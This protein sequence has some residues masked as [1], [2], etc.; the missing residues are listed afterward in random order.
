MPNLVRR[1]DAALSSDEVFEIVSLLNRV[2]PKPDATVAELV[3]AFP[4]AQRYRRVAEPEARE[5]AMRHLIREEAGLIA[6]ALTF[7]R[8]ILSEEGEVRLMALSGVCVMPSHRG[9]GLGRDIARDSLARVDRGDFP[10]ALFQTGVPAFYRA[11]GAEVIRNRFCD[12]RNRIAPDAN[13]WNDEWIMIYPG[14]YK[15]PRGVV[16]LNGPGY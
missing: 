10:V 9:Q 4:E 6:H 15:W 12:S 5:P 16:D 14:E 3:R 13:P 2:W 7:E 11:L 1:P 8:T